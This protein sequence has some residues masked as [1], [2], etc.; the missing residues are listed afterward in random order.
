[1]RPVFALLVIAAALPLLAADPPQKKT[2]AKKPATVAPD[3]QAKNPIYTPPAGPLPDRRADE[4]L[5]GL[6]VAD[7]LAATLFAAEPMILNPSCLDI[8]ARGRVWVGEVVNYRVSLRK[9]HPIREAG[10]RI[11]ILQDDDGDGKAD[12]IKT[13][14]QGRDI[15]SLHGV[16]VLGNRLIVSTPTQIIEFVD[17]NADDKP[18]RKTVRFIAKASDHDHALHTFNFGVDGRLY[19]NT[20]NDTRLLMT[21][22][23]N[24]VTDTLGRVVETNGKPFREGMV[25][26]TR[27]DFSGL[28]QQLGSQHR[29]LRNPLAIRQRRRRQPGRA[30]QLRH[31]RRQLRLQGRTHRRRVENPPHQPRTRNPTAPLASQRPRRR[32]QSPAHRRRLPHRLVRL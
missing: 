27:L 12:R 18:D 28:P 1:M 15:D 19:F 24:P 16:C 31:A 14:Y 23:G 11:L 30:H 32:A 13:Y 26:R 7:G 22:D 29:L 8:D 10:D 3:P 2:A 4:A 6:D 5:A 25:F 21:A 17:D 9:D 20:G